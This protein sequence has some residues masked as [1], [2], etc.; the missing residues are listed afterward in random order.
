MLL[1]ELQQL[2][3]KAF[4]EQDDA[5]R[6]A[7]PC[8]R[9]EHRQPFSQHQL[10]ARHEAAAVDA[11]RAVH[12]TAAARVERSLDEGRCGWPVLQDV[13]AGQV[14]RR[15]LEVLDAVEAVIIREARVL[16]SH[17]EDVRHAAL[18]QLRQMGRA[19]HVA[20]QQM[21]QDLARQLRLA[22]LAAQ[23]GLHGEQPWLELPQRTLGRSAVNRL[24][25]VVGEVEVVKLGQ[26]RCWIVQGD[27]GGPVDGLCG[28]GRLL[29]LEQRR[30]GRG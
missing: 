28:P 27:A 3:S 11:G 1:R 22:G 8:G 24:A 4:V 13:V 2:P 19:R 6:R 21:R 20:Q 14:H 23:C 9:L 25:A 26:P 16:A 17:V 12:E 18:L 30:A 7:H 29:E 10:R 15:H 5:T